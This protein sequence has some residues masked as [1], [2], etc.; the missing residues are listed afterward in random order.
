[1]RND[2]DSEQ[3]AK[4][5]TTIVD[6]QG[7]PVVSIAAPETVSGGTVAEIQQQLKVPNPNLWSVEQ[8]Y[9]YTAISDVSRGGQIV[10][11]Y[12]TTFEI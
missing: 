6:A 5:T 3:P 7:V 8:P 1:V 9:L 10:D 2:S 12:V 4:L 11:R